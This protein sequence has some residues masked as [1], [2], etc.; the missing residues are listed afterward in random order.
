[1]ERNDSAAY[2]SE[3]I[4]TY[5]GNKR[6]LLDHL[7]AVFSDIQAALGKERLVCADIFSGSGFVA[8]LLKQFS[9]LII[10]NDLEYYS[11][12]INSCYLSNASEFDEDIYQHNAGII[13]RKLSGGLIRGIISNNYAPADDNA[14]MRGERVFFTARNAMIIDTIRAAIDGVDPL[15]RRYFLAPLLYE[16]SVH[17]N[18]GGVF[19]GFYKDGSN[20]GKFGGGG[21]HALSRIMGE[22]TLQKPVF[23]RHETDYQVFRTD[24]NTLAGRLPPGLDLL[25]IDPPYNQHPYGS[26]YF[27]LNT[28]AAQKL[29]SNL[30]AVSGIPSDWN[31]SEYNRRRSALPKLESLIAEARSKYTVLSYNSEGFISY[32]EV[33]ETL[34]KYGTVYAHEI[35]YNTYRASRNLSARP[36]HVNEYIFVLKRR[37]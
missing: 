18:T 14:V 3:Q 19:K 23:S 11:Q 12:I 28:V 32:P 9:S 21:G 33:A 30:S 26:N 25:Y 22:I 29:G 5:I 7:F 2:L 31:R 13:N 24:A 34:G 27:M 6:G 15:Y 35:R 16:V 4:I 10:A 20:I 37:V 36:K 1:M 17:N 8:R